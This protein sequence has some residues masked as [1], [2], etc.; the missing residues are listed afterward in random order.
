MKKHSEILGL[1]VISIT[2]GTEL[3]WVKCIVINSLKGAVAAVVIEDNNWYRVG[4]KLLPFSAIMGIGDNAITVENSTSIASIID[5][6]DI[7]K[8]LDA[9]V[10]V[11]G[12]KVLTQRGGFQGRVTEY[13]IDESGIIGS[14][15]IEGPNGEVAEIQGQRVLTFG[16]DIMIVSDGKISVATEP[17]DQSVTFATNSRQTPVSSI[18]SDLVIDS[19]E[20]P[21]AAENNDNSIKK[22]EEKQRTYLLGKKANRRIEADN[23]VI[24]VEKGG[25]ITKEVIQEAQNAGKL[26]ELS[27]SI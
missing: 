1:P 18:D 4:A 24:I 11:I 19:T 7:Q 25:E 14:C 13:S 3:G 21:A 27:M 20:K 16:K 9:N 10:K 6:S 26:V 8:L 23:G 15:Q 17:V 12:A 2:D 22:F 5:D